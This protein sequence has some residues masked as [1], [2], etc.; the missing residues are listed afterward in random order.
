MNMHV[1]RAARKHVNME[2][3]HVFEYA[4]LCRNE[5]VRMCACSLETCEYAAC[6]LYEYAAQSSNE[7]VH[8][9]R[10]YPRVAWK[11]VNMQRLCKYAAFV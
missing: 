8:V 5:Y 2:H 7:Y 11:H 10:A 1:P 9:S 3:M 4:P 6:A